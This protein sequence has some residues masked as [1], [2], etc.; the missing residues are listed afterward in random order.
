MRALI[1]LSLFL[2][3]ALDNARRGVPW[4]SLWM[5]HLAN[6]LMAVGRPPLLGWG[7]LWIVAG[8][9]LWLRELWLD[10]SIS[11]TSALAHVGGLSY[12]LW[13]LRTAEL[14]RGTWKGALGFFLVVRQFCRWWTPLAANVNASQLARDGLEGFCPH[15]WQYWLVTSLL[16]GLCLAGLEQILRGL[17]ARAPANHLQ[18]VQSV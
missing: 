4:D 15:F 1:P 8:T 6:L 9:P 18:S 3:D 7:V 13:W 11:W 2:I 10:P 14:P 16:C 17:L 5:C 12:A